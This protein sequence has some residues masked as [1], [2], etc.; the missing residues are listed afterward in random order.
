MEHFHSDYFHNNFNFRKRFSRETEFEMMDID[1]KESIAF[2]KHMGKLYESVCKVLDNINFV[3]EIKV[4]SNDFL[5]YSQQMSIDLIYFKISQIPFLIL[6]S[7]LIAIFA[8]YSIYSATLKVND[9]AILTCAIYTIWM[10]YNLLFAIPL[11]YFS[12][13]VKKEVNYF[14]PTK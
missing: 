6:Y 8:F 5:I 3:Y 12:S 11:M 10:I 1:V 14:F 4:R 2:V 7:L 9:A 13:K